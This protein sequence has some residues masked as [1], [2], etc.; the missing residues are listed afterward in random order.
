MT[1]ISPHV[2]HE[3]PG[4]RAY[5]LACSYT[6]LASTGPV[7]GRPST[8]HVMWPGDQEVAPTSTACDEHAE[9]ARGF[10]IVDEHPTADSACCMPGSLW[11]EGPPSTCVIDESGVEPVLAG[12]R[13][14]VM[15]S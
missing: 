8:T 1:E 5:S 3:L 4:D 9:Y 7:C 6:G 13:E 11:V 2:G 14:L 10:G 15:A 12:E